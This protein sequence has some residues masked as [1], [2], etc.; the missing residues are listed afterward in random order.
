MYAPMESTSSKIAGRPKGTTIAAGKSLEQRVDLATKEAVDWLANYNKKSKSKK[1]LKK[2]LLMEVIRAAKE[3]YF[4]DDNI[5]ICC[6]TVRQRVKRNSNSGHVGQ[7][8][9]MLQVEPYLV[10]LIIKLAEMRQP[11]TTSQGLQVANSLINGTSTK[12]TVIEW[13]SRNCHAFKTG[14]GKFEL[15]EGYWRGFMTRNSHLIRAKKAV[16]FDNKRA[17]W[18]NYLNMYEMYEEIYKYNQRL[19]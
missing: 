11:I 5:S 6:G 16:K 14:K 7:T 3:K 4:V 10:E 19:F 12:K 13:K 8:S 9:P 18:C 1:R 15:S 2:G 17:Q